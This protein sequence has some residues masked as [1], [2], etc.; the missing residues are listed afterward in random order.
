MNIKTKYSIGDTVYISSGS[1]I[2]SKYHIVAIDVAVKMECVY[3][4]YYLILVGGGTDVVKLPESFVFQTQADV[5]AF[6]KATKEAFEKER[7]GERRSDI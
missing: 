5:A 4:F 1:G 7:A 6:E 3:I 2:P